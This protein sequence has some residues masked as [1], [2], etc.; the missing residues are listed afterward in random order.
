VIHDL[1]LRWIVTAFFVISATEYVYGIAAGRHSWTGFVGNSLHALMAIAMAVMAWPRGA[2]LPA[3]GPLLFFLLASVWFIALTLGRPGHRRANV[4]HAVM[5]AA[6][7]WMYAVMSGGVL[8]ASSDA[9]S[10]GGHHG[11]SAM[12]GMNMSVTFAAPDATGTP[13]V[14]TGLNWF[15]TIGFAVAG[16]CWLLWLF[17]RRG[18][19]PFPSSRV[20]FGIAAQVMMA[21]GMAI[22]FAVML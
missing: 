3:T 1:F 15:F 22:M 9:A 16:A 11:S 6:M 18:T 10:A 17:V 14:I 7:A 20:Q 12:P 19:E 4:Y 5:M 8:P 21:A 2:D 13:P